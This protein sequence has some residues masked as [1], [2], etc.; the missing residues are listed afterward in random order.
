M[1]V[2]LKVEALGL[3]SRPSG[4]PGPGVFRPSGSLPQ[5]L[6]RVV[7]ASRSL[8]QQRVPLSSSWALARLAEMKS[9]DGGSGAG[10]R[11]DADPVHLWKVGWRGWAHS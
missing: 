3:R 8:L 4:G 11:V 2:R 9:Q 1:E 7:T 6:A 10:S 5:H